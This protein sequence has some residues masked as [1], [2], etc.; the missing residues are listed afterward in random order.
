M[1]KR[2]FLTL[3]LVIGL[4]LVGLWAQTIVSPAA[5]LFAA[6]SYNT[7]TYGPEWHLISTL[8]DPA[9]TGR[10]L[11]FYQHAETGMV[12]AHLYESGTGFG[13]C[14]YPGTDLPGPCA[15]GM[16]IAPSPGGP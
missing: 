13:R 9:Q 10:V 3:G 1:M 2:L 12:A 4:G 7:W 14:L 8:A 6:G 16:V 15:P 11:L 5:W